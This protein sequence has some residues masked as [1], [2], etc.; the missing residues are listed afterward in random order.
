MN[1]I[2]LQF[3][4]LS[5]LFACA[6]PK[7]ENL[8]DADDSLFLPNILYRLILEDKSSQCGYR[9]FPKLPACQLEYEETHLAE[10]WPAVKAEMETQFALGSIGIESLFQ[11]RPETVGSVTGNGSTDFQGA[12]NAPNGEVYFLP[13]D[14]PMFLSI[15]TSS[16]TYANAGAAPGGVAFI[17]GSLGP[18]GKIYLAPHTSNDFR[19]LD[20]NNNQQTILG[21]IPMISA[22]YNGAMYAPNG[23]IYFVPSSETIIRYYDTKTGTIGSVSTPTSGGFSS[24]VLTPQGKIYFIPLMATKMYILDTKDDSV[25]IHPYTFSGTGDY[26]SGILAPN[27]RIYLIPYSAATLLYLDTTTD[28]MVTVS[29]IPAATSTM[30]NGAVLAPNGKIYPVPYSYSNFISIDTKDHTISTL[31]AKPAGSYRGG[32]LGPNGEIYLAPH[33]ANRFDVIFTNSIGKFCNSLR[34]SPYWNKL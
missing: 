22:A 28:Q 16:K 10:N 26:I 4:A 5:F 7:A 6:K 13:Y 33:S 29:N 20:T 12:L 17:G 19:S 3:L 24:A 27:G 2:F 34:L 14:S 8:C 18:T 25:S 23:K 11:Y 9:I 21:N 1:R 30:F 31:F 32:A 15:N